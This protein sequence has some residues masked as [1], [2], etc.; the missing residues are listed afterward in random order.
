M[1]VH[2]QPFGSPDGSQL[3]DS[4]LLDLHGEALDSLMTLRESRLLIGRP[5]VGKTCLLRRL[6]RAV[7]A[8]RAPG[9]VDGIQTGAPHT[10][11]VRVVEERIAQ[12]GELVEA[13]EEIW[14]AALYRSL[15]SKL[16]TSG[17]EDLERDLRLR[18]SVLMGSVADCLT[19]VAVFSQIDEI[20]GEHP[21]RASLEA[22]LRNDE[23]AVLSS[24]LAQALKNE[25]PWW[26]L[27][28]LSDV[29]MGQV[30]G[31]WLA[32]QHGLLR[33]IA[34]LRASEACGQFK[35]V[36]ATRDAH[37]T[38]FRHASGTIGLRE[39]AL[40][41]DVDEHA[42]AV[43]CER[44]VDAIKGAEL[45]R[46]AA[47]GL[48]RLLGREVVINAERMCEESALDYV[49][50]HT[51]S[52]PR[53]VVIA[54]NELAAAL[55]DRRVARNVS[56][57]SN[58]IRDVVGYCARIYGNEQLVLCAQQQAAHLAPA[59]SV[60]EY[61]ISATSSPAGSLR[62]KLGAFIRTIGRDRFT[63]KVFERV[64]EIP[65]NDFPR[66]VLDCLWQNGLV[67]VIDEKVGNGKT[68]FFSLPHSS[69][70]VRRP[71][72]YAFHPCLIDALDLAH[73]GASSIPI[74]PTMEQP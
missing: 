35:V 9:A 57:S 62:T 34:R 51:R 48:L 25:P 17:N 16:I 3:P 66:D 30:P 26:I 7:R 4:E 24:G 23:W 68:T 73:D 70:D 46:P 61:F 13:W 42:A 71:G 27:L 19:P 20:L 43:F 52:T 6:E 33:A 59:D 2:P 49:I 50:R 40:V 47:H 60:S 64:S 5:G 10:S 21:G 44:K 67:G 72:S 63:T 32:C 15:V 18:Y 55:P 38:Q 37:Y 54:C 31:A 36:A 74:K 29:N 8:G 58:R 12:T 56:L 11:T 22:Y 45:A 69:S 65:G 1:H 53:D 41:I 28:D 14:V 39:A